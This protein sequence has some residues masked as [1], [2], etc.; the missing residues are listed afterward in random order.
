MEGDR[1]RQKVMEGNRRSWNLMEVSGKCKNI[2][3]VSYVSKVKGSPN[4]SS[5]R[6]GE[7]W[8]M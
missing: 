3:W 2:L 8:L 1:K 4:S 5:K 6:G 7:E